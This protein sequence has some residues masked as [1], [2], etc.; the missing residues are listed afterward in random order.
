MFTHLLAEKI[1]D[2]H[3]AWEDIN[4]FWRHDD[5]DTCECFYK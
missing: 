5:D 3:L 2:A 4:E 1:K